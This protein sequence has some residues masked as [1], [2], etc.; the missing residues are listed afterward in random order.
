MND[1]ILDEELSPENQ[2]KY[3]GF[4]IRFGAAIID[5]LILLPFSLL[6]LLI[7]FGV[8]VFAISLFGAF[9]SMLYK[10]FMEIKYGATVGKMALGIKVIQ[11]NGEQIST[12]DG[13]KRFL[14]PWAYSSILSI[15]SLF[16]LHQSLNGSEQFT[17][18]SLAA[19]M[20]ETNGLNSL[21]QIGSL[22]TL[23][24]GF[25]IA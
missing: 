20:Q 3:A 23:I 16:C 10:P 6:Y 8:N 18:M 4:W 15:V 14:L 1:E 25:S 21:S 9:M 22:L 11:T 19:K 17:F 13:F 24:F 5:G 12:V 2:Y 7:L